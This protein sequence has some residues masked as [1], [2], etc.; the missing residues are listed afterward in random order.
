MLS[1]MQRIALARPLRLAAWRCAAVF[2][3]AT[4]MAAIDASTGSQQLPTPVQA[5]SSGNRT[6][7]QVSLR[8]QLRV[9]LKAVTKADF[10]F[11][12]LVVLQVEQGKLPRKLVDATFLWARN[13]HKERPTSHRLR[14]IV[15]FQPALT[16]QA[17]KVG[18]RL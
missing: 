11:I 6:G 15:Y 1:A 17:K 7:Q 10:A 4:G 16:L 2:A 9:G 5:S 13:R 14:P 18:V 12:D 3:C 8:D